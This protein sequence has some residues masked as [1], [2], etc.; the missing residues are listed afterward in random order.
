MG[1]VAFKW[2]QLSQ[3]IPIIPICNMTLEITFLPLLPHLSWAYGLPALIRVALTKQQCF[4]L[5]PSQ[6]QWI[7]ISNTNVPN[8]FPNV[9][10]YL[11]VYIRSWKKVRIFHVHIFCDIHIIT[12]SAVSQRPVANFTKEVNPRL[13]TRPLKSNGGLVKLGLTSLVGHWLVNTSNFTPNIIL[14]FMTKLYLSQNQVLRTQSQANQKL[15]T[16]IA[17]VLYKRFLLSTPSQCRKIMGNENTLLHVSWNQ[18]SEYR[19]KW[20]HSR[21]SYLH[22]SFISGD[23]SRGHTTAMHRGLAL[24]TFFAFLQQIRLSKKYFLK[25]IIVFP[26]ILTA[27]ISSGMS[28]SLIHRWN[29]E[30]NHLHGA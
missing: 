20:E 24:R 25:W 6:F 29:N 9:P 15:R 26:T 23:S 19:F 21:L 4:L 3:E 10:Y 7:K 18:F 30:K 2:D 14:N 5:V 12:F 11:L 27:R 8:A 28:A 1:S 16:S 13:T 17:L 22:L